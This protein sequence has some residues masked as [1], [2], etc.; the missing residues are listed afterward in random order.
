MDFLLP[1]VGEIGEE[2]F[3][4]FD[5]LWPR[6]ESKEYFPKT[7]IGLVS[8][9]HRKN[10]ERISEKLLNQNYQDLHHFI[11][12]SPWDRNK[13]NEIRISFI[14]NQK[15]AYPTK[16][17]AL[18]IDDT[19][20]VKRG[21]A[22]EGVNYQY[23]G[24]VGKVANGNVFVTS[25]LTNSKRHMPLDIL[26]YIPDPDKKNENFKTKIVL[27]I[28]LID[29]AIKRKIDF[30]FVLADSWYGSNPDF[31][32]YLESKGLTY[33]VG[34][35]TNRSIFFK[36]PG[37]RSSIEHKL[38]DVIPI[39]KPEQFR[40]IDIELS[41][42]TKSTRFITRLD[43]KIKGIKGKRRVVI[44]TDNPQN[45][46]AS[47][48]S[49]YYLSNAVSLRDDTVAK[50]YYLRNWIEVFY[51]EIKDFLGADDYQVRAMEKIMR[52]WT[53][54]ITAYSFLQWLQ[55]SKKFS[56]MIKKNY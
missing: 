54:C 40:P 24:Q 42:G 8:E 53:L 25:H 15:T 5:E 16:R 30:D 33:I 11:T 51:R 19:G 34:I 49:K 26:E 29:K 14:K 52:H 13:M 20:V 37:E 41:N 46:L 7:I 44:E 31:I 39:L 10:I 27:A 21:K 36:L 18:V 50:T 47:E 28:E 38:K 45:P 6:R 35:K 9:T 1:E 12:T 32:E 4:A 23:I 17:A 48:T 43:L 56:V 22:T 2:Y 55:Y 3:S